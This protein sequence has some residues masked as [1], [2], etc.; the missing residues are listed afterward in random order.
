I[1]PE[2]EIDAGAQRVHGL[3]NT[4]LADKPVFADVITE[5]KQYIDGAQLIIHNAPFDL[6][7]LNHEFKLYD[8]KL[9]AISRYCS[10]IDTLD[11]ARKR[12]PGQ[13]NSL[14]ALCKRYDVDNSHRDL[15]G[16]LV[17]A[18]L[19]AY[20]YLAMT[21][22]QTELFGNA[23]KGNSLHREQDAAQGENQLLENN[24]QFNVIKLSALEQELHEKRVSEITKK[25]KGV[26]LWE[27]AE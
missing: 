10:I 2:R 17:D 23:E 12:H 15:H 4:F 27:T 6:G 9:H 1:N 19:L 16:A 14:D 8:K 13:K 25:A 18:S 22:G 7:F 21:G 5:F 11:M 3:S 24:R 26:N 20:V